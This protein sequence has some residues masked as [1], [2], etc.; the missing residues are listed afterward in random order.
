MK[1]TKASTICFRVA[2]PE[3]MVVKIIFLFRRR[4]QGNR[5]YSSFKGDKNS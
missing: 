4:E 2:L 3:D 5:M 1:L